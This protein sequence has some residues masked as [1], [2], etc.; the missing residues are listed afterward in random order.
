MICIGSSALL[1]FSLFHSQGRITD[2]FDAYLKKPDSACKYSFSK[3]GNTTTFDLTSQIWQ[4]KPWTHTVVM[5]DT[6]APAK[7]GLGLIFITGSGPRPGDQLLMSTVSKAVKLPSAFLF[8]I[9]N[10]PL[11]G[12][13]E[14]DLISYTFDQ[15]LQ[16]KDAS[17]PLLFPMTKSVLRTMDMIEDQTKPSRNPI[18]EFIIAG[19]SKRGWTTWLVGASQDHRVK[20]IA[21]MV[22]DN[23]NLGAQMRHQ[24]ELWG[25]YSEQI[26]PYTARGLQAKFATGEGQHLGRI[27]DPY[28]YRDRIKV[29]TLVIT[30]SN[31]PYWTADAS[32]L[33]Y[34]EL[35][36]PKWMVTVPNVGHSLGGGAEAVETFGAFCQTIAGKARMPHENWSITRGSGKSVTVTLKSRGVPVKKLTA[37]VNK[38]A[39]FDF[40]L[41]KYE[42]VAT[43]LTE[44]HGTWKATFDLPGDANVSVFGEAVYGEESTYRLCSPTKVY[45]LKPLAPGH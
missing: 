26:E 20:A 9:P 36:Q 42:P 45:P 11:Y 16:T 21:P 23:L 1:F 27:V 19:A 4:G 44:S 15:Y 25:R 41:G 37:W 31:D 40:R 6:D 7:P 30:G 28:T 12:F 3:D 33:Y 13:V 17:W 5:K 32:S 38:R 8:S 2:E 22:I 14:D 34:P 43:V 18:H 24:M 10:Q 39:D 35:K 29:P